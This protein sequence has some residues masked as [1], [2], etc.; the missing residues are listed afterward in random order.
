MNG[1]TPSPGGPRRT[2]ADLSDP[3][4]P[5][6]IVCAVYVDGV[7]VRFATSPIAITSSEHGRLQLPGDLADDGGYEEISAPGDIGVGERQALISILRG[8]QEAADLRA[9]LLPAAAGAAA[10]DPGALWAEISQL[11]EGDTW[12][13]R[14]V[15]L[16][17]PA[18]EP[19]WGD[20]GEPIE[21]VVSEELAD[22]RGQLLDVGAAVDGSTWPPDGTLAVDERARG[23]LAPIVIGSPGRP[24]S[25]DDAEDLPAVPV[26]VVRL[27]SATA[28]NSLSDATILIAAHRLADT[29]ASIKIFNFSRY[30]PAA[31]QVY[32]NTF[33]PTVTSDADGREVSTVIATAPG[34]HPSSLIIE[35]GDEIYAAFEGTGALATGAGRPITGAGDVIMWAL[36]LSTLRIAP[37]RPAVIE[38][39]NRYRIDGYINQPVGPVEWLRAD[40]LPLLPV[41]LTPGPRGWEV[42][43]WRLDAG[44]ADAEWAIDAERD[45]WQR[46]G[47]VR[48]TDAAGIRNRVSISFAPRADSGAY[49][50]RLGLAPTAEPAGWP[51]QRYEAHPLARASALRYGTRADDDIQT[52]VV[53]DPA[54][55]GLILLDRLRLLAVTRIEVEYEAPAWGQA[56]RLGDVVTLTD[57]RVGLAAVPMWVVGVQR[58]AG[59]ACRVALRSV[60]AG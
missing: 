24:R 4:R 45:G 25:D 41:S 44:A 31:P 17:G 13:A 6:V 1:P 28:D 9:A 36:G 39:L 42:T 26:P 55:A 32:H 52:A 14:E 10:A 47:P 33:A 34:S 11:R 23:M 15:L 46:T 16:F 48:R 38:R 60:G 35:G 12:E 50:R 22:D 7:W 57:A 8:S 27:N 40:I 19:A 53:W 29:S 21:L 56:L 5:P 54:T 37:V 58:A 18:R 59:S 3:A 2:V 49:T 43:L 51:L 20:D 30:Q